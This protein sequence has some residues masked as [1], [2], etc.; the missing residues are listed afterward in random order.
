MATLATNFGATSTP[1]VH[2]SNSIAATSGLDQWSPSTMYSGSVWHS[3]ASVPVT[4]TT[5]MQTI[6]YSGTISHGDYV[7][8][9]TFN[10]GSPIELARFIE[11][12]GLAGSA[13]FPNGIVA[14]GGITAGSGVVPIVTAAGKLA[15]FNATNYVDDWFDQ[16]VKTTDSPTF[17]APRAN[18]FTSGS[19]GVLGS[20]SG[21]WTLNTGAATSGGWKVPA[22][23]TDFTATGGTHY[24]VEQNSVGAALPVAQPALADL[25]DGSTVGLLAGANVWSGAYNTFYN[26]TDG[27]FYLKRA[28]TS[29][30][31]VFVLSTG[32][33]AEWN[34]GT[35][36]DQIFRIHSYVS[37]SDGLTIDA[38]SLAAAVTG[39]LAFGGGS[40]ISSSNN[41]ALLNATNTF[42]TTWPAIVIGNKTNA[43]GIVDGGIIFQS[44]DVN[45][46]FYTQNAVFNGGWKYQATGYAGYVGYESGNWTW[47]TAPSG[48]A[49]G[50]IT[51]TG[52]MALANGGGLTLGA[53]TGGSEGNGT[54]NVSVGIYLNGTAYTNPIAFNELHDFVYDNLLV[55]IAALE[56][57]LKEKK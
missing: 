50:T 39:T 35:N 32:G 48:S 53:P 27:L 43:A 54:I 15:A 36:A 57:A 21:A 8:S 16:S 24:F 45:D 11:L 40:A 7:I 42:T 41:V 18:S 28:A 49:A 56:A 1:G 47:Y 34:V 2:V 5:E 12:N 31:A 29:G 6:D 9:G 14:G 26:G 13:V 44:Y 52:R 17:N 37:G 22:G 20:S 30:Y 46:L 23:S 55:R 38:T 33:T 51:M 3:G 10:G 19:F 4:I 25:S